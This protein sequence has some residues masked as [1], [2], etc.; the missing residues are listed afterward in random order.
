MYLASKGAFHRA[1]ERTRKNS[2]RFCSERSSAAFRRLFDGDG[3]DGLGGSMRGLSGNG[4]SGWSGR[5]A[6]SVAADAA[7]GWATKVLRQ[8]A[9]DYQTTECEM[10]R[11]RAQVGRRPRDRA[12]K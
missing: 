1:K 5:P 8:P 7:A 2:F 3:S 11:L 9:I 10:N 12:I 4:S 6:L